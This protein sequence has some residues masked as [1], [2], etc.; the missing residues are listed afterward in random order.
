MWQKKMRAAWPKRHRWRGPQSE[1]SA[2]PG[3]SRCLLPLRYAQHLTSAAPVATPFAGWSRWID[4]PPRGSDHAQW[5]GG[6]GVV[7]ALCPQA[8]PRRARCST[9]GALM[10]KICVKGRRL[11]T[12]EEKKKNTHNDHAQNDA[13]CIKLQSD[14]ARS[15]CATRQGWRKGAT[16][17][18]FVGV[19]HA[20][21]L[22][23]HRPHWGAALPV[24]V[25]RKGQHPHQ[26]PAVERLK[27]RDCFRHDRMLHL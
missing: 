24:R 26:R 8:T 21:P 14:G 7:A 11:G 22:P 20:V 5:A 16:E 13:P 17:A 19:R 15:K 3:G 2:T 12:N 23:E 18:G 10:R 9:A 6:K 27:Q 4:G 1:T 25:V